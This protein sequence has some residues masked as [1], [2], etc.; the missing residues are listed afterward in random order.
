MKKLLRMEKHVED[1]KLTEEAIREN[2]TISK[3]VINKRFGKW[4]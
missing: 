2:E 3:K 1:E 4:I